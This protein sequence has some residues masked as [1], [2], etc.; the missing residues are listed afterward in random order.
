MNDKC[1]C[2]KPIRKVV[3]N[4]YICENERWPHTWVGTPGIML[5]SLTGVEENILAVE[6]MRLLSLFVRAQ[7]ALK[8]GM[9]M[10]DAVR[11]GNNR[12]AMTR[13]LEFEAMVEYEK[14][15]EKIE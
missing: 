2:G 7:D 9:E 3:K 1:S 14:L 13:M 6:L 15:L 8:L 10:T 4:I 12:R 11:K 5:G